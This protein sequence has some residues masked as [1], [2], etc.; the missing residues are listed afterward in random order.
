MTLLVSNNGYSGWKQRAKKEKC[1]VQDKWKI[2]LIRMGLRFIVG[3]TCFIFM[4]SSSTRYKLLSFP[5]Y[6]IEREAPRS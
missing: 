1:S 6:R 5:F 4:F 2:I 3:F